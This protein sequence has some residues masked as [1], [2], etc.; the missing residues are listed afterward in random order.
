[1]IFEPVNYFL[2][3]FPL[4][5]RV[6]FAVSVF[7]CFHAAMLEFTA[8]RQY[9]EVAKWPQV[10]ASITSSA[11]YSAGYSWSGRQQRYCPRLEYTY[12]VH[13]REYKGS[14]HVF[15]FVCWPQTDFIANHQPG[16]LVKIAYDPANPSVTVYPDAMR[17]PGYPWGDIAGGTIFA[18]ILLVD[19]IAVRR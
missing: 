14:N 3:R 4:L 1:L 2:Q 7:F 8:T 15:D 11:L 9:Q 10:K 19:L 16:T 13:E 5:R 18:L 17:D 12:A 6:I